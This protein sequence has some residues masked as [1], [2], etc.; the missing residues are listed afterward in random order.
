M[1]QITPQNSQQSLKEYYL[2]PEHKLVEIKENIDFNQVTRAKAALLKFIEKGL[3]D[4]SNEILEITSGE[5][6]NSVLG[7]S[8]SIQQSHGKQSHKQISFLSMV[9]EEKQLESSVFYQ[10]DCFEDLKQEN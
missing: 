10:E 4:E 5:V 7:Y 9:P 3:F 1:K 8:H 6:S 2:S